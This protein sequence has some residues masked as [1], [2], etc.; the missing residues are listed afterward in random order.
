MALDH[1]PCILSACDGLMVAR[2]DLG[3]ELG[4]EKVPVI[5]KKL[6]WIASRNRVPVIT[7]TQMLE[8]MMHSARPLRAEVSD[9]ANAVFNG[10]D[11][12]M[13]SGETAI[14]EHPVET[15]QMMAKIILEAESY[16]R[17]GNRY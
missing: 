11:R 7:A 16:V 5:Q 10:T 15:V 3:I 1:I 13:L 14:G 17:I 2:G 12:V 8:S 4:V 6:I 9:V